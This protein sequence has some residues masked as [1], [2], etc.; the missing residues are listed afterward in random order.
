MDV[1]NGEA[2]RDADA[3]LAARQSL[4][5]V[6]PV[7]STT[8]ASYARL[9]GHLGREALGW[10]LIDEAGQATPQNAAGALWRTRRAVVVGDPLQLEPIT[11]LPFRA[12][13]AI[14]L[15]FD[16]D[17]QWLTSHTSV[18][19][20][21]DRLTPLG[22]WLPGD[23]APTWVG[24]PLTVHRH[25]DQPMFHIVNTVAYDGLT[26]DGTAP[27]TGKRFTANYPTLPASKWIDVPE[28]RALLVPLCHATLRRLRLLVSP[29]TVPRWHRDLTKHRHAPGERARAGASARCRPS[30]WQSRTPP[31]T[32][33]AF[34]PNSPS[35][36]SRSPPPRSGRSS[37]PRA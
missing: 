35:L 26:I 31:G 13:Q 22:T 29:D 14:R 24:I 9:F 12:E 8:F 33:G 17:E 34:T 4:F 16:V 15:Q 30:A 10:L 6:V 18:Q 21:T 20:L 25:C 36:V 28:D 5:F 2:P 19:R 1:V 32:T 3:V 11:V 37:R 23:D 27:A 7:V